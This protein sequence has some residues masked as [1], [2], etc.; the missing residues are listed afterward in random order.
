[1]VDFLV[2]AYIKAPNDRAQLDKLM[3]GYEVEVDVRN[4]VLKR[5]PAGPEKK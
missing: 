5:L 4:A 2:Y 1:M 3:E